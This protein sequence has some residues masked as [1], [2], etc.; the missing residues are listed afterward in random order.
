MKKRQ[1]SENF[2]EL[3]NLKFKIQKESV[4]KAMDCYEDSPVYEEVV[5]TYEEIYEEMLSLV[6]PVGI[7]GF[8]TLPESVATERSQSGNTDCIHGGEHW[9]RIKEQS[10]KAFRKAT[11]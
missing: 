2:Y 10:T 7:L 9:K 6:E 8:G 11:M 5:D 3:H 4:L 1:T